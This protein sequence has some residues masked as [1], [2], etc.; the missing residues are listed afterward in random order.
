LT[1]S[2]SAISIRFVQTTPVC[3]FKTGNCSA[4]GSTTQSRG[5]CA[6]G[7]QTHAEEE[8][9]LRLKRSPRV[10]KNEDELGASG[11][12]E[13]YGETEPGLSWGA[14]KPPANGAGLYEYRWALGY[15]GSSSHLPHQQRFP[16]PRRHQDGDSDQPKLAQLADPAAH[17]RLYFAANSDWRV[18]E[19][20]A[21]VKNLAP[22]Q[23]ERS[24][25][26]ELAKDL[27][28]IQPLIGTAGQVAADATGMP[29][30]GSIAETISR[31]KLTS[32]PQAPSAEWF[33]RRIDIVRSRNLYH[34]IEWQLPLDLLNQLG[35]RVTGGLLVSFAHV[36]T[37]MVAT[38]HSRGLLAQAVLHY[39]K[40]GGK[41]EDKPIPAN[42]EFVE[43]HLE[44]K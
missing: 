19:T 37:G 17:V 5:A 40:A 27:E 28:T 38:D 4:D 13:V 35:S 16:W 43:L 1:W 32:V 36:D 31:L 2:S 11:W 24:W 9:M 3:R 21:T 42:E 15:L 39:V 44:P 23:D 22:V 7:L 25:R 14:A 10:P 41:T 12:L 30:L 8:K 29:E 34:G 33:V 18:H 6:A 26:Q 20:L